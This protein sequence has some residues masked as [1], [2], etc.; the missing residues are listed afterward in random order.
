MCCTMIGLE[1]KKKGVFDSLWANDRDSII[2]IFSLPGL[3]YPRVYGD[4]FWMHVHLYIV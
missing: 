3:S 2:I 4:T 1:T